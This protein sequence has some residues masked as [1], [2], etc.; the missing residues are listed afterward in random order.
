MTQISIKHSILTKA[1]EQAVHS[2]NM[3]QHRFNHGALLLS[4]YNNV[5]SKGHNNFR[6]CYQGK[7]GSA[8]THAEMDC[9]IRAVGKPREK[10]QYSLCASAC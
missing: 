3:G 2:Q 4:S 7:V 10:E 8:S 9:I 5:V 1:I 6:T